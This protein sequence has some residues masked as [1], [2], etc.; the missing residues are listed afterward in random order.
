MS[1]AEVLMNIPRNENPTK[2]SDSVSLRQEEQQ[3]RTVDRFMISDAEFH[4]TFAHNLIMLFLS[5]RR[6]LNVIYSF[7]GN[8]PAS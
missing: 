1:V 3:N 7:L 5:F 2:I 8:S 4:V 6:V